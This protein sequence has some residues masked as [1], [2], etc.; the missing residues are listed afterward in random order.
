MNALQTHILSALSQSQGKY[1]DVVTVG[2]RVVESS[3]Q[4]WGVLQVALELSRMADMGWI[5]FSD[6]DS[7]VRSMGEA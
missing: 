7:M 2:A 5:R 3:Q 4:S 6:D 1:V